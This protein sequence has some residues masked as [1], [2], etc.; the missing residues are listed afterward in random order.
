[1]RAARRVRRVPGGRRASRA[2]PAP[3]TSAAL[4]APQTAGFPLFPII[5]AMTRRGA[6]AAP[7]PPDGRPPRGSAPGTALVL[8]PTRELAMQTY[9]EARKFAYCT[10]IR[11]VVAYGGGTCAS[12]SRTSRAA[13]DVLVATPGRLIDMVERGRVSLACVVHLVLDEADRMLDMGFEPQIRDIV[14]RHGMPPSPAGAPPAGAPAA[15]APA[16][17]AS[18]A[19]AATAAT[20]AAAAARALTRQTFMFSATFPRNIQESSRPTS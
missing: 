2:G 5:T 4:L 10:G 14:E 12:S 18:P 11:P 7:P 19:T 13:R 9:E 1:M 16:A 8:S 15:G 6:A 20:A 17:G 3:H